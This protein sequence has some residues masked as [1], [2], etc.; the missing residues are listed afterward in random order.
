LEGAD[1]RL[2]ELITELTSLREA[3]STAAATGGEP[4][5]DGSLKLVA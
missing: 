3:L 1:A 2:T 5:A 4:V